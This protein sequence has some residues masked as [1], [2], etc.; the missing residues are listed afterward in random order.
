[1]VEALTTAG[2]TVDIAAP[3]GKAASVLALKLHRQ[4]ECVTIHRLLGLRPGELP[5][6]KVRAD[7]VILDEASMI[8]SELMGYACEALRSDSFLLLVGDPAQLSPVGAGAPF[9]DCVEGSLLPV[10]HLR[11]VQR[12]AAG[13][14]VL[15]LAHSMAGGHASFPDTNV[16]RF[17][18]DKSRLEEQALDLYCSDRLVDRFGLTDR[19]RQ[20]TILSPVKQEKFEAST[21]NLNHAIS[22][23]LLPDR[24]IQKSK[25]TRGDRVMFTINNYEHGFVN[26]EL[27][28]LIDYKSVA[29]TA[30]IVN[31]IDTEYVLEDYSLAQYMEHAYAMTVHKAQGSEAKVVMLLLH[32]DFKFMLTR[33]LL[34]TAVTRAQEDLIL[35]G[36]PNLLTAGI[37]K[38]ERRE[39]ALRY[40]L[41]GSDQL[42]E[43]IIEKTQLADLSEFTE[44]YYD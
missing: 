10:A 36:D 20:V 16:H 21:R 1:L 42:W 6:S 29:R 33:N 22:H 31:D 3:T 23:R 9:H 44:G 26:G 2:L 5:T 4:F 18:V 34:Y 25:F 38:V 8:D 35:I 37:Q 12:Q 39:T 41:R 14:G 17:T 19:E 43:Q 13:N 30:T 7:V 27:G 32:P 24:N 11:S 15:H 40:L 28:K